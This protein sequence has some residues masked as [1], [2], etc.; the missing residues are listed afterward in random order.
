MKIL[1]KS[2]LSIIPLIT[3]AIPAPSYGDEGGGDPNATA[4]AGEE[5]PDFSALDAKADGDAPI[6]ESVKPPES[7]EPTPELEKVPEGKPK[8][9]EPPKEP[10]AP[11]EKTPKEPA[12]PKETEKPKEKTQAELDAEKKAKETET[13]TEDEPDPE[14]DAIKEAPHWSPEQKKQFKTLKT[15]TAEAKKAKKVLETQVTELTTKLEAASK[16]ETN[17]EFV[18][19]KAKA[20]ELY[21]ENLVLK[22][23]NDPEFLQQWD[24]KLKGADTDLINFLVTHPKLGLPKEEGEKLL[25]KLQEDEDG[26]LKVLNEYLH[27][28]NET[29]DYILFDQVKKQIEK[30]EQVKADK[31]HELAKLASDKDGYFKSIDERKKTEETEWANKAD[32]IIAA[33]LEANLK[34]NN[35]WVHELIVRDTDTDE[36]KKFKEAHNKHVREVVNP[37]FEKAFKAFWNK[38]AE[39]V[40]EVV[41]KSVERDKLDRELGVARQEI[42]DLEKR[43]TELTE[44]ANGVKQVESVTRSDGAEPR[45]PGTVAVSESDEGLSASEAIERYR[46]QKGS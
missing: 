10:E 15:I 26:G 42:K 40:T 14:L 41:Y 37:S 8:E 5:A 13:K 24:T 12:L 31:Q 19:V 36:Q 38:D 25:K 45:K 7:N 18:K 22:A 9:K 46:A 23:G 20:E 2:I 27:D 1:T 16:L 4:D 32:T 43:V 6:R 28:I 11:K 35:L 29:K 30:R 33:K 44:L 3:F 17:E 21:N 34:A 39:G